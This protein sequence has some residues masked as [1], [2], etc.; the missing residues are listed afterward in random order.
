MRR[1]CRCWLIEWVLGG[2][3]DGDGDVECVCEC[4]RE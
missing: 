3:S 4:V 2:D 1:I